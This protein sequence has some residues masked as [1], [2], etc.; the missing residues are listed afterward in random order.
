MAMRKATI[1][2][3]VGQ[4]IYRQNPT[5]RPVVTIMAMSGPHPMMMAMITPLWLLFVKS[6]FITVTEQV[7]LVQRASKWTAR[8]HEVLYAIP[9]DQAP[10]LIGDVRPAALY[11]SFRFMLPGGQKPSRINVH[12]M[13]RDEMHYLMQVLYGHAQGGPQ[14]P[15]QQQ[16]F[17]GQAPHPQQTYPY[18]Q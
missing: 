17:P 12:R 1:L 16:P 5:D 11:S 7:V 2:Q 6:Y 3:Q 8:P 9:R 15:M 14:V 10:Y 4:S 13:W 18:G